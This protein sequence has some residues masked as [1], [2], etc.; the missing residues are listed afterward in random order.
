MGAGPGTRVTGSTKRLAALATGY[1]AAARIADVHPAMD[2]LPVLAEALAVL[3]GAMPE[4]LE[5]WSLTDHTR[6]FIPNSREPI[7]P[8]YEGYYRSTPRHVL[9]EEHLRFYHHFGLK[10]QAQGSGR[11]P[12]E[13]PLQ[14][15]CMH[16][17]VWR[18]LDAV[19]CGESIETVGAYARARTELAARHLDY[20][21]Q[22]ADRLQSDPGGSAAASAFRGI[23]RLVNLGG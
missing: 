6:W 12:D 8:L 3:E 2:Q 10:I 20:L 17:L 4:T 14:L 19:E 11:L 18:Q 16:F 13:L 5:P 22:I 9:L 15:E 7:A 21:G 1:S 23:H